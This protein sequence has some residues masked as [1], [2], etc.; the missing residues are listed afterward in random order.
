VDRSGVEYRVFV[1]GGEVVAAS[2]SRRAL[3]QY[4]GR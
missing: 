2:E 1:V 3:G 4:Y